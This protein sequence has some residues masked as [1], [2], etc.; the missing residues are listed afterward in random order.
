MRKLKTILLIPLML[1][2]NGCWPIIGREPSF[3]VEV[4]EGIFTPMFLTIGSIWIF[5]AII[6]LISDEDGDFDGDLMVAGLIS[7]FV[8]LGVGLLLQYTILGSLLIWFFRFV[9]G[10]GI[11]GIILIVVVN[12][13]TPIVGRKEIDA[14]GVEAPEFMYSSAFSLPMYIAFH[15]IR[16]LWYIAI[17]SAV[18]ILIGIIV[19]KIK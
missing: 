13:F 16:L 2:L 19:K 4:G 12:L 9:S 14:S 15:D 10:W 7:L 5:L 3:I 6:F 11:I 18:G 17:P 1:L 8:T